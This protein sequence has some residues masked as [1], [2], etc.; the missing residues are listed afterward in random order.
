MVDQA[1]QLRN[2][3]KQREQNN[4]REPS[5]TARLI[6]ITSGKG[7]VG[8][9]N[10]AVNL[11]VQLRR[12]GKRVLIFDA[13]FG[14]A[15]VEVMFGSIPKYNLFD[16]IYRGKSIRDIITPGPMDI[17]FISGGSGI[18]GLNNLDREQILYL[19][20]AVD[21]L[22]DLADFIIVDTGA[23]IS[24][25][26]LEFVVASPEVLLIS[27]PEPSSLTDSYSL[28]KALYRNPN[29]MPDDA[30]I[31]VIANRVNS[32]EEGQN[33]YDKLDSVVSQFLHGKLHYLGLIPQD[34]ALEKAVRQQKPVAIM[35]PNARSS[36]ALETI[37]DNL[38]NGTY[39][40]V[41]VHWG[42]VQMFAG[43][44]ANRK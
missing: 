29:F 43:F 6:T 22:N 4:L 5:Q 8:K 26:V 27:T 11:A 1:Q 34:A 38:L 2:V 13:D 3:I 9:S 24:D 17:G 19:V 10:I 30:D 39:N 16:F 7:G 35:E 40:P 21:E 28:L 42:I 15:N 37:A 33:V 31:H 12:A 25:Q 20:K 23:G 44:L 14:L 32:A 36:R 41:S 18:I